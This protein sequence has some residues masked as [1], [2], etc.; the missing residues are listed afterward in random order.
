MS[1]PG[2]LLTINTNF[3]T[4]TPTNVKIL[5]KD[6][7]G[8]YTMQHFSDKFRD[9][10]NAKPGESYFYTVNGDSIPSYKASFDEIYDRYRDVD[11]NL[12]ITYFKADACE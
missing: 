12:Y 2:W 9:M 3:H 6:M 11:G 5:F 10:I 4:L 1:H 8:D 7:P